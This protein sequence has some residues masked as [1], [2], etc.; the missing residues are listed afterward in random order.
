[1]SS[2][3]ITG[4]RDWPVPSM[5]T[6]FL[7]SFMSRYTEP[8]T[9]VNGGAMGVDRIVA[10]YWRKQNFGNVV[11]VYPDW[12]RFGKSAGIKRNI[13][14]INMEPSVVIAFVYNYSKGASFTYKEALKRGIPTYS[15]MLDSSNAAVEE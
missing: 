10:D 12:S 5:I 3:L 6:A 7:D 8:V 15:I 13:D 4:S 9:L 14:M 2:L 1:M 11:T